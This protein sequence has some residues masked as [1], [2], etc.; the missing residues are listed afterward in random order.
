MADLLGDAL[1]EVEANGWVLQRCNHG[2]ALVDGAGEKLE[3]TCGCRKCEFYVAR[4]YGST[5]GDLVKIEARVGQLLLGRIEISMVDFAAAVMGTAALPAIF[6]TQRVS[7]RDRKAA[8]T[9]GQ[10]E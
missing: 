9:A 10:S 7:P 4:Q 3:P 2:N 1:R 8:L 5:D 6:S